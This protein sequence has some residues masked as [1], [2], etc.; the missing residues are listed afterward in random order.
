MWQLFAKKEDAETEQRQTDAPELLRAPVTQAQ[1]DPE[2]QPIPEQQSAAPDGGRVSAEPIR[3]RGG[4]ATRLS[5]ELRDFLEDNGPTR[6]RWLQA[7]SHPRGS[8]DP[9]Q[10][11]A[12]YRMQSAERGLARDEARHGADA[13]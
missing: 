2:A 5:T 6:V 11:A 7:L 10:H 3:P 12:L 13:R 1:L 9:G 8:A 4:A